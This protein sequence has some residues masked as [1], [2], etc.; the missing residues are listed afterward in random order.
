M[1]GVN[2]TPSEICLNVTLTYSLSRASQVVLVVENP[3]ANARVV[4]DTGSVPGSGR[5]PGVGN[6]TP[7]QYS[8]LG[9][10]AWSATV[11][12]T[13]EQDVTERLSTHTDILKVKYDC[14]TANPRGP[15]CTPHLPQHWHLPL[16]TRYG[17]DYQQSMGCRDIWALG[18]FSSS[19]EMTN[20]LLLLET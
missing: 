11:R 20:K 8:C 16:F 2:P 7:V 3:P 14:Q 9:R 12:G 13:A 4:G 5:F 17:S 1:F 18:V 10:G 15:R 19:T 6:G